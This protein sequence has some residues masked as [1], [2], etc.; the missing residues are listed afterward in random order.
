MVIRYLRSENKKRFYKIIEDET[1][2]VVDTGIG[3]GSVVVTNEK[4]VLVWSVGAEAT[5]EEFNRA[6]YKTMSNI[7]TEAVKM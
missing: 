7:L 1:V 2:V 6:F 5:E 4:P 3:N